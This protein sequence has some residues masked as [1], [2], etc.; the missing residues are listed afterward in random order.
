MG[1]LWL[2]IEISGGFLH[3]TRVSQMETLNILYLIIY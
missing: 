1:L 2:G 3:S